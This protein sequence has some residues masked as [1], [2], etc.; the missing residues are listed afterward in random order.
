MDTILGMLQTGQ[1]DLPAGIH[2]AN[3]D[4]KTRSGERSRGHQSCR[5]L[6]CGH[7]CQLAAKAAA[8]VGET[9]PVCKVHSRRV[10]TGH[11]PV[12]RESSEGHSVT[13]GESA[14][15]DSYQEQL[16][17][18]NRMEQALKRSVTLVVW[19]RVC[20]IS[21]RLMCGYCCFP[22]SLVLRP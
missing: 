14:D 5:S 18:R 6:L 17:R 7:C 2:C 1:P 8:E 12:P 9:R 16:D 10:H 4:C 20:A 15:L 13:Q 3:L 19:Y 22:A 11:K 21:P